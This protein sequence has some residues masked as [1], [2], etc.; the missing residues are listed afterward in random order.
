MYVIVDMF[1]NILAIIFIM[2]DA[3]LYINCFLNSNVINHEK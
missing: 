2:L 3:D 1:L